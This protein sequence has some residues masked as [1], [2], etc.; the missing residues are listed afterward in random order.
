VMDPMDAEPSTLRGRS[1]PSSPAGA[2]NAVNGTQPRTLSVDRQS[3][4]ERERR[5][6]QT[7]AKSSGSA[8]KQKKPSLKD[9][10]LGDE[11]GRGSYSTVL[12]F[13]FMYTKFKH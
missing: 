6:S 11:L 8:G 10:W 12:G 1:I 9:Y 2:K 4:K 5:Q 7:S 13:R 3:P